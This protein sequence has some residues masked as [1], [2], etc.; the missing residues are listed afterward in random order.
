MRLFAPSCVRLRRIG[1]VDPDN[2]RVEIPAARANDVRRVTAA[3]LGDAQALGALEAVSRELLKVVRKHDAARRVALD[4]R[5][6]SP[7]LAAALV[8]SRAGRAQICAGGMA[9]ALAG[10]ERWDD[11][12][13]LSRPDS[14]RVW[15]RML[16]GRVHRV[17]A[18]TRVV[19]ECR[20]M[21]DEHH[22]AAGLWNGM[23]SCRDWRK[24]QRSLE[25]WSSRILAHL[26]AR[27]PKT[28]YTK[29]PLTNIPE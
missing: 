17:R 7:V 12:T 16:L 2:I 11:G 27:T 8:K 13:Q 29:V 19:F 24:G 15:G 25:F 10:Y 14:L 5:G 3:I 4:D 1:L 20:V 6:V 9:A 26:D 22:F 28:L 18:S 21:A 23:A